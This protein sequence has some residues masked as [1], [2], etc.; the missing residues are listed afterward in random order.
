MS[1][2]ALRVPVLDLLRQPGARREL[3]GDL[4]VSAQP[5]SA[6]ELVDDT[7]LRYDLVAEAH[8]VQ[9]IVSGTASAAWVGACRRCL[10]PTSGDATAMLREVFDRDHVEGETWP[11][12]RDSIELGPVLVQAVL[13]ELPH[14]TALSRRLPGAGPRPL[15]GADRVGGG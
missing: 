15:P 4:V 5:G 12:A 1:G 6:A 2:S 9:V 10:A 7:E 14:R 3:R 8:G 11:I 13:L